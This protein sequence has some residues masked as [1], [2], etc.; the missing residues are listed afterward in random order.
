MVQRQ[1]PGASTTFVVSPVRV[2]GG[3]QIP[4]KA[5]S[6]D[7]VSLDTLSCIPQDGSYSM[8]DMQIISEIIEEAERKSRGKKITLTKL[9]K[10][11]DQTL[12][13]HGIDAEKDTRLYRFILKLSLD[14]NPD[15]WTKFEDECELISI[16]TEPLDQE[17]LASA[18]SAW[19]ET[20]S[21]VRKEEHSVP[22]L[23]SSSAKKVSSIA[24]KWK[25]TAK[26]MKEKRLEAESAKKVSPFVSKWKSTAKDMKKKRLEAESAKKVSPFVSKWKSTAKDMKERRR[27]EEETLR[28]WE[29]AIEFERLK[30]LRLVFQAWY[31]HDMVVLSKAMN[32]WRSNSLRYHFNLWAYHIHKFE[33]ICAAAIV[34][35]NQKEVE[36]VFNE[37]A[38]ITRMRQ[39]DQISALK[40]ITYLSYN[41]INKCM[42]LWLLAIRERK[43]VM[44]RSE[45]IYDASLKIRSINA[46]KLETCLGRKARQAQSLHMRYL[47]K[48]LFSQ[49]KSKYDRSTQLKRRRLKA[50]FAS[51]YRELEYKRMIRDTQKYGILRVSGVKLLYAF[52]AWKKWFSARMER[53]GK[54]LAFGG[55]LKYRRQLSAWNKW[56]SYHNSK[57]E[58]E[59][60]FLTCLSYMLSQKIGR[61]IQHWLAYVKR[62]KHLC[63]IKERV[64][65]RMK[66][67]NLSIAFTGWK[68][69]IYEKKGK[70]L[71]CIKAMEARKL[72][73]SFNGFCFVVS[74]M[75][76]KRL[77]VKMC[78]ERIRKRTVSRAMN[79]WI[80]YTRRQVH[81]NHVLTKSLAKTSLGMKMKSFRFWS[82]EV[83]RVRTVKKKITKAAQFLIEKRLACHFS[84]WKQLWIN[85][86]RE[87]LSWLESSEL[88]E[89]QKISRMF[90]KWFLKKKKKDYARMVLIH[91]KKVLLSKCIASWSAWSKKRSI[92]LKL[93][94]TLITKLK[95]NRCSHAFYA[96]MTYVQIKSRHRQIV[97]C[98]R[99]KRLLCCFLSWKDKMLQTK[100]Q[101]SQL[102]LIV[103]KWVNDCMSKAFA[104]WMSS[105]IFIKRSEQLGRR[106]LKFWIHRNMMKA[107]RLLQYNAQQAK[108]MRKALMH[109]HAQNLAKGLNAWLYYIDRKKHLEENLRQAY[110]Q[111]SNFTK[112]CAF[113]H[114][115]E[116][117]NQKEHRRILLQQAL[118]WFKNSI[119]KRGFTGWLFRLEDKRN[120]VHNIGVTLSFWRSR[121]LRMSLR[122]W[123]DEA[124]YQVYVEGLV[125]RCISRLKKRVAHKTWARWL[126]Y[127]SSKK[128]KR[129]NLSKALAFWRKQQI[130]LCLFSWK[131]Y[132]EQKQ[133]N[134]LKITMNLRKL[135]SQRLY[136]SFL[137]W[138]FWTCKQQD[139]RRKLRFSVQYMCNRKLAMGFTSWRELIPWIISKRKKVK[140]AI[141]HWSLRIM[142]VFYWNWFDFTDKMKVI[143]MNRR[144]TYLSK[145]VKGWKYVCKRKVELAYIL[146]I[147]VMRWA[148]REILTSWEKLKQNRIHCKLKRRAISHFGKSRSGLA[149][150]RWIEY[151]FER[152]EKKVMVD[153]AIKFWKN[154]RMATSFV[155]WH[156]TTLMFQHL[157][158]LLR[159]ATRK[160]QTAQR[161]HYF[162]FLL[163]F[164][165]HKKDCRRR[166]I[167]AIKSSQLARAFNSWF[168]HAHWQPLIRRAVRY[169]RAH[170]LV[171]MLTKWTMYKN[172]R[173]AK[174]ISQS[175][176]ERS[177][178]RKVL[179]TWILYMDREQRKK[180]NTRR[181]LSLFRKGLLAKGFYSWRDRAKKLISDREKINRSLTTMRKNCK[182]SY[183]EQWRA[184]VFRRRQKA[185]AVK[186]ACRVI[187][188]SGL[189]MWSVNAEF[190]KER[191]RK[192]ERLQYRVVSR[193]KRTLL[194]KAIDSWSEYT[195]R[196]KNA[197]RILYR[198]QKRKMLHAYNA[199]I[200]YTNQQHKL[201]YAL[202]RSFRKAL[203]KSFTS[204]F[205]YVAE[206]KRKLYILQRRLTRKHELVVMVI[207]R[208][209]RL[210]LALPWTSWR[211]FVE[212]KS[213]SRY[214]IKRISQFHLSLI[215]NYWSSHTEKL[216]Q[217]RL[218]VEAFT[219]KLSMKNGRRVF[220]EW[221]AISNEQMTRRERILQKYS[222]M[223][224]RNTFSKTLYAWKSW[225]TIKKEKQRKLLF[226]VRYFIHV[227]TFNSFM[228]WKEEVTSA[229]KLREIYLQRQLAIRKAIQAGE[230]KI[231]RKRWELV[232][233]TLVAWKLHTGT[234]KRL[235]LFIAF[236]SLRI[237]ARSFAIWSR[238]ADLLSKR[239]KLLGRIL[240][241][242]FALEM[243]SF[244]GYYFDKWLAV[245][246]LQREEQQLVHRA[247]HHHKMHLQNAALMQW[248]LSMITT[249]P[250]S[251]IKTPAKFVGNSTPAHVMQSV[252]S[253]SELVDRP[254]RER[255]EPFLQ[256]TQ[257][258]REERG[259]SSSRSP[260][261]EL[262][263]ANS[264]DEVSSF[265]IL[266]MQAMYT[267]PVMPRRQQ[268]T[269][270]ASTRKSSVRSAK[271][272]FMADDSLWF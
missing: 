93:M 139:K 180:E 243:Y 126:D 109:L 229:I 250:M 61:I 12:Y 254:R 20:G 79:S 103:K 40:A 208:W 218:A 269:P 207:K 184:H 246:K 43:K 190:L 87:K 13:R 129:R 88:I 59:E 57:I 66:H 152:R 77:K 162:N 174:R 85:K 48:E 113:Q 140:V 145:A 136:D 267:T 265:P 172:Y 224:Q 220:R 3:Y 230:T 223:M 266:N 191:R 47:E 263:D 71:R 82:I 9:L 63:D 227:S 203:M 193:M 231:R 18:V 171:K 19:K 157:E 28:K 32:I 49:W 33:D 147:A 206:K 144:R 95:G 271:E 8:Q 178:R 134:D 155:G 179:V 249:D 154:G 241:N 253:L 159:Q 58:K 258:W 251:A 259:G 73:Y 160:W 37:W 21:P 264:D 247:T 260:K 167:M 151:T 158:K 44:S 72:L 107:F 31:L 97:V 217:L 188:R 94:Q 65:N 27:V 67:F 240:R 108:L 194:H 202:A 148:Y 106:A 83:A 212:K 41:R 200:Y 125:R 242:K 195:H 137:C 91:Y 6:V 122:K 141:G 199:W 216:K 42:S 214:A 56:L 131:K 232:A 169:W 205:E 182:A 111:M 69:I 62:E 248:K 7:K 133:E 84:K 256:L 24:A 92:K 226:A 105:I 17:L 99:S 142:V 4:E 86:L 187:K 112:K 98:L 233:A 149:L 68:E 90:H 185:K 177:Y 104:G 261:Y 110:H 181:A 135:I 64:I 192:C 16:G 197:R 215:L 121:L 176:F 45:S 221:R 70:L 96:W 210:D 245:S 14:P 257:R 39:L 244:V 2:G 272:Y 78:L 219:S 168:E 143:R 236:R 128:V 255:V 163:Q 198:V 5:E 222:L 74:D 186:H 225:H 1:S 116:Y 15:W 30:K 209:T 101:A 100:Y 235:K 52:N 234:Y 201:R 130:P 80:E 213:Y 150:K 26:D 50:S 132:V 114:W 117:L 138:D 238:Y 262:V 120:K 127:V 89:T 196:S 54:L 35:R 153:K 38:R 29:G 124:E 211:A 119:V 164:A 161:R 175:F 46:W 102:E 170:H 118:I 34:S 115:L 270:L 22:K 81:F 228:T 123:K 204:W 165:T 10:S 166:A 146:E 53:Q 239:R 11:Y 156:E 55:K 51:W 252:R 237:M 23:K 75:K 183:L 25:S 60:L 76:I 36:K 268:R 173:Q 189:K